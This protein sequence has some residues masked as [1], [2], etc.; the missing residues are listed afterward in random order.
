MLV[1]YS[2][3]S[4][5]ESENDSN[6]TWRNE[7]GV[8]NKRKRKADEI[9]NVDGVS[10]TTQRRRV[11]EQQHKHKQ[12]SSPPPL[13]PSFA[14]L[15]ATNVR[16]FAADD[17]SLHAG[18]KR[19]IPHVAGNWPTHVFLEWTPSRDQVEILD[20]V[21][22]RVQQRN[23]G[24]IA[25]SGG[26]TPSVKLHS[27]LRSEL[28][29]LLPLHISL[30]APLVLRTDQKS[31]FQERFCD[32]LRTTRSSTTTTDGCRS[33][34]SSRLGLQPFTVHVTGL[35]WV[36]NQDG[37]RWFLVLKLSRPDND[38]LNTLLAVCNEVARRFGLQPLYEEDTKQE[39]V[40]EQDGT[41]RGHQ[42]QQHQ[43]QRQSR[44]GTQKKQRQKE[45]REIKAGND[46]SHAFH[47]S[48]AW[49]LHN[50]NPDYFGNDDHP[51][52]MSQRST[53]AHLEEEGINEQLRGLEIAFS[54]L[55]LKIGNSVIDIPFSS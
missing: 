36:A 27:F 43:H 20:G 48:I 21:I 50:P 33:G 32:E 17:P 2:K 35:D 42:H 14:S 54:S 16:T 15:Y 39:E 23:L 40:Q 25:D 34:N 45:K 37:S 29:A 4:N 47:I 9:V 10:G 53:L 26:G 22:D 8:S 38:E 44:E 13:P 12:S 52:R 3:S 31:A 7:E 30:S 1:D 46:K 28:G 11:D 49:A 51:V 24:D 41:K 55:K 5:S 19:Q 6:K 18:R